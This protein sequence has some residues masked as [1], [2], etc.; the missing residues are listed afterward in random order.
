MGCKALRPLFHRQECFKP[1][2]VGEERWIVV[3]HLE[4]ELQEPASVADLEVAGHGI[5]PMLV[6]VPRMV[7]LVAWARVATGQFKVVEELAI[8]LGRE[9]GQG[10]KVAREGS[11]CYSCRVR[12]TWARMGRSQARDRKEEGR[13]RGK[14]EGQEAASL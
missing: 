6:T 12:W 11:S 1:V 5:G 7:G 4:V 14:A 8:R 2:A 13:V 3:D 9:G 10:V